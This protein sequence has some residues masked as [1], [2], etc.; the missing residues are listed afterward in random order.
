MNVVGTNTIDV[1]SPM[2]SR[3]VSSTVTQ[4]TNPV[5]DLH[6]DNHTLHGQ[7]DRKLNDEETEWRIGKDS[8]SLEDASDNEDDVVSSTSNS[9]TDH[10]SY[11]LIHTSEQ[12]RRYKCAISYFHYRSFIL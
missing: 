11:G 1:S 3:F 9:S 8:V 6:E 10:G 7:Y 2:D 5:H 4:T 12:V